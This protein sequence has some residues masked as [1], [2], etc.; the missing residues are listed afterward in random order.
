MTMRVRAFLIILTLT[1][2][3]V[4]QTLEELAQTAARA[5]QQQDYETAERAYRQ[6]LQLSPN[7]VE[8][9]SNLGVACYSQ[10]KFPCAE[11]AFAHALK[12]APE[13]FVPNFL[14]GQIRF[15]QDRYQEALEVLSKAVKLQ[16]ENK[17]ARKL[18]V[19]TWVGLKQYVLA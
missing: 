6:F 18:H 5:M 11:E 15:Q 1:R 4:P 3:A 12:L 14:L 9:Q 2:A 16:P 17:R 13:L 7:V 8:V 10:N 19:A